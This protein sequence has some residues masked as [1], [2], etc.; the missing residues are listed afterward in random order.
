MDQYAQSLYGLSASL[1]CEDDDEVTVQRISV[2]PDHQGQGLAKEYLG[3][4][5][6]QADEL[7]I[8]LYLEAMPEGDEEDQGLGLE[9]LVE[10]YRRFG[11]E[12]DINGES[13]MMHRDPR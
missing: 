9:Q 5:T 4:L 3:Y 1:H 13:A 11:F 6:Q 2:H 8:T 12:G 10:L 7:S